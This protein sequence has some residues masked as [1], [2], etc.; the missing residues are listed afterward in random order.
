ML[1]SHAH[2]AS[3]L[4]EYCINFIALNEKEILESRS[5]RHFKRQAQD[6]LFQLFMLRLQKEKE[7]SYLQIC[8]SNSNKKDTKDAGK[9]PL[10]NLAFNDDEIDLDELLN[11]SNYIYLEEHQKF[12]TYQHSKLSEDFAIYTR[13]ETK[14]DARLLFA[15]S[16]SDHYSYQIM[17]S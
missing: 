10:K 8:I 4:E 6:T 14:E 2:N 16:T 15:K 12:D 3:Q 13:E 5:F 7:E 11:T 1:I 9:Y 17:S